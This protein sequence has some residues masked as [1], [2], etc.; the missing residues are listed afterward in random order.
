ML[1]VA[2]PPCDNRV[3]SVNESG[4]SRSWSRLNCDSSERPKR[5][6]LCACSIGH[7]CR[8]FRVVV[9]VLLN[10]DLIFEEMIVT[11]GCIIGRHAMAML[12]VISDVASSMVTPA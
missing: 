7:V 9:L 10:V 12:R 8:A 1:S 6:L 3:V 11:T 2:P 5:K 4:Y